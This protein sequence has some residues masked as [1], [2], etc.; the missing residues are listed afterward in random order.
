MP[1]RG[2]VLNRVH[3]EAAGGT[4]GDEVDVAD[5]VDAVA[6][7][8]GD[9]PTHVHALA[10]NF[11]DYQTLARGE[12]LRMEQFRDALP[13]AVPVVVV[14]NFAKD[15]HDLPGLAGMHQYLFDPS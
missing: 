10:D 1:L 13:P 12:Q 3:A 14:P 7:V 4:S 5:V 8:L 2:V 6:R 9:D 15:V 11:F